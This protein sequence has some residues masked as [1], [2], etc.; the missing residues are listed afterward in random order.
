MAPKADKPPATF[1]FGRSKVSGALIAEYET[2]GYIEKG[3]GRAPSSET[4]PEPRSNKVVVFR[5]LFTTGL[6]FPLDNVVVS[7]IRNFGM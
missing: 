5:D 1:L 6:R 2:L 3:K 4:I 7:I